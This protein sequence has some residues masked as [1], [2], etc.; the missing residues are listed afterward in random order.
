MSSPVQAITSP[1]DESDRT[2]YYAAALRALRFVERRSPTTRRFGSEADAR[3][4]AF[5]GNLTTA[6]RLDLLLRDADAHWPAAFGARN[7]FALRSAAE[8]EAFGAEWTALDPVVADELWRKVVAETPPNSAHET[9]LAAASSWDLKL[10]AVDA[11]AIAPTDKLLVVGPSAVA[12]VVT[13]FAAGKDLD[14]AAQVV[15]VATPP[16]HRQLAAL[17]AAL[18]NATKPTGLVAPASGNPAVRAGRRL[19]MSQDAAAE[20]VVWARGAAAR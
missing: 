16:A 12:A 15:C 11:G 2:R 19:I 10:A 17:G 8:D 6:D 9:L 3:W 1:P 14:W 4:A 18:L 13:S 7:V 5:R 20:D